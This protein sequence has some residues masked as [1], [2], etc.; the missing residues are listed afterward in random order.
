MPD[1]TDVIDSLRNARDHIVAQYRAMPENDLLRAC[2]QSEV[3]D[4]EPWTP[5]D[6]L[7]HLALIERAFQ[8]ICRRTIDGAERPIEWE[9]TSRDE[10][11]AFVHRMNQRNVEEHKADDVDTLLAD[12]DAARS[13]TLAFIDGL[14]DEQ[15]AI[16]I[17]G[18]PWGDG[19]IAGVL[20]ALAGHERMH[21]SW[22]E[23]GLSLARD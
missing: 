6:H 18:A 12:M 15:L 3:P 9:G 8:Q 14:T 7:A 10:I 1:R 11:L 21:L 20:Q 16:P 13:G 4:G 2:T 19:T 5:K 17:P 22:T 23:E